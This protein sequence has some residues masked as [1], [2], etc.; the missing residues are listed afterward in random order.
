MEPKSES[1]HAEPRHPDAKGTAM[2]TEDPAERVERQIAAL[3]A[4]FREDADRREAQW[5]ADETATAERHRAEV[6]RVQTNADQ[7]RA[8]HERS[9]QAS[10]RLAAAMETIA[11]ALAATPTKGGGE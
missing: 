8:L 9:I 3:I 2:S 11:K 6:A 1:L 7:T 4:A 5:K 10:E